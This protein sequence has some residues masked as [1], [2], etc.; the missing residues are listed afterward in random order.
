VSDYRWLS[1]AKHLSEWPDAQ[2]GFVVTRGDHLVSASCLFA[3]VASDCVDSTLYIV[4]VLDVWNEGDLDELARIV[5]P[6]G[7]PPIF[8]V[9]LQ[10]E[11]DE[12]SV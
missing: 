8:G 5:V 10:I 1:L 7:A 3:E 9:D 11:L 12:V 6:R 2:G 4:S